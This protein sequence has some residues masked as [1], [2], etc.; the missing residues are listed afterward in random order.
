MLPVCVIETLRDAKVQI[1]YFAQGAGRC[2]SLIEVNALRTDAGLPAISEAESKRVVTWTI[3]MSKHLTGDAFDV[4]P[5]DKDG[6]AWW[7]APDAIWDA[8][9][10]AA[11]KV[12]LSA[13]RR[14]K[15]IDS[16]HMERWE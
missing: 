11:E 13:G 12:G 3:S 7:N 5:L 15:N 14:W 8:M 2:S 9:A 10:T 6:R 1:A 4:V 16:P